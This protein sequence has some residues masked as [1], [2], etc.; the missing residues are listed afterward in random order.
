MF[1]K[2]PVMS[3]PK[4]F[5][6]IHSSPAIN[7]LSSLLLN[8]TKTLFPPNFNMNTND[9]ETARAYHFDHNSYIQ[10]KLPLIL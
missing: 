7:F 10:K 3:P 2:E 9:Y 8:L 4:C 1:T 6:P 5:E